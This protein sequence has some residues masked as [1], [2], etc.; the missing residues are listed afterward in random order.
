MGKCIPVSV[1]AAA[2][3]TGADRPAAGAEAVACDGAPP[4]PPLAEAPGDYSQD[5]VD[6]L[7]A[8]DEDGAAG[9]GGEGVSRGGEGVSRGGEGV[10][11]GGEGVSSGDEGVS[12]GGEGVSRGGEG[13]SRG[14]VTARPREGSIDEEDAA[15][16][17][18]AS[19]DEGGG[20]AE[21]EEPEEPDPLAA[22]G[23]RREITRDEAAAL[24]ES[25]R[26]QLRPSRAPRQCVLMTALP[27]LSPAAAGGGGRRAGGGAA[28]RKGLKLSLQHRQ[29]ENDARARVK[30]IG[31]QILAHN[32]RLTHEEQIALIVKAC[33]APRGGGRRTW[34]RAD[35]VRVAL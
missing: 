5:D 16:T 30:A 20:G 14:D 6:A 27:V 17:G 12:R 7:F 26:T 3:A 13:V 25:L 24:M 23:A 9:G 21:P 1:A 32:S 31:D 2:A 33:V 4:P 18:A 29:L 19:G 10:S 11:R 28:A 15:P 34:G 8:D 22:F 35:A